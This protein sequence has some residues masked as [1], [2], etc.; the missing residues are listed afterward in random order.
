[1]KFGMKCHIGVDA[2]SGLVIFGSG[3]ALAG[4]GLLGLALSVLF[5]GRFVPFVIRGIA[6]CLNRFFHKNRRDEV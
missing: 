3:L 1:M 4:L 2:G 6:D 5:Y